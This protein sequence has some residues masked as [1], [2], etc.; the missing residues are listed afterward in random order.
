MKTVD[1]LVTLLSPLDS[2]FSGT[3]KINHQ[4]RRNLHLTARMPLVRRP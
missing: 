1:H 4:A 2:K 3:A